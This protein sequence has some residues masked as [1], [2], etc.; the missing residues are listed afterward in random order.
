MKTLKSSFFLFIILL[1]AIHAP[2][3]LMAEKQRPNILLILIDDLGWQDLQCYGSKFYETPNIDKLRT[4]GIMFTNAYSACPVCSPTRASI[5]TGKNPA[6]LQFTGHITSVGEHRYPEHGRIIPP[7]DKMYVDLDEIM[8]PEALKSLG[9]NSISIGKWHVGNKEKYFPT[10]Q[11]FDMNIAGYEHGS[12]PTYWGPYEKLSSDWNPKIKNMKEG[13]SGEYLTDRLTDE[14]ISFI[15]ANK[16]NPFFLY[17]SHYAVHTPLE[18]SD[19][20]VRKYEK[21]WKKIHPKK[22]RYMLQ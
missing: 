21:K 5:L 6:H 18:A 11:G 1:I 15:K 4:E 20:L 10:H 2:F 3:Q 17:L 7:D 8:I 9:Y 22:T 13:K 12:P 14:A 16:K 19:S